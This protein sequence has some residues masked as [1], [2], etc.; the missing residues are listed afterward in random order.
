MFAY[1]V[2]AGVG[3]ITHGRTLAPKILD[4]YL[5]TWTGANAVSLFDAI[6]P[7]GREAYRQFYLSIDFWFPVLSLAIFYA[8]LLSYAFP[9]K[10]RFAWLNV[11]PAAMYVADMLE[12]VTHFTIAGEY[13]ARS[14][15]L[16]AVG[17]YFT[18]VKWVFLYGLL[19]VALFG[20]VGRAVAAWR[21]RR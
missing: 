15:A 9:A 8:S 16:W 17:P 14:S 6:G 7:G 19:A 3:R 10:S 18:L 11:L 1:L 12:N 5:P 13:P 2:P 20:L 4:E 21:T